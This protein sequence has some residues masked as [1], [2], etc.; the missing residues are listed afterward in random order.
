MEGTLEDGEDARGRRG[1]SKTKRTL[2]DR[3]TLGEEK[4]SCKS[5]RGKKRSSD[6]QSSRQGE[7]LSI[8]NSVKKKKMMKGNNRMEEESIQEVEPMQGEAL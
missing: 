8:Y 1:R 2:E 6:K 3:K 5:L 4:D 7:R